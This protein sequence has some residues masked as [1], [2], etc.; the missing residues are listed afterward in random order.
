MEDATTNT[1]TT[2]VELRCAQLEADRPARHR[3][4]QEMS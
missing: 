4:R 3:I 2:M 1:E